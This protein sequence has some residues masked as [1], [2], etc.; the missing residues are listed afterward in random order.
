M[1]A[2]VI[3]ANGQ[4]GTKLAAYSA[5]H[6]STICLTRRELDVT[7]RAE[8]QRVL[9]ELK[10]D[11][12]FN[13]SAY[14]AVDKAESETNAAKAV[15]EE[16]PRYIAETM[17]E[18]NGLLVHYSTDYV[19]NGQG[20]Q[21]WKETDTP[22]PQNVYGMTKWLG[23]CAIR[24]SG[25]RHLIFR[26]SWVY[27]D[28][29]NNFVKTMLRLA[30]ERETLRVVADQ[31]G[32]PCSA[33]LAAQISWNCAARALRNEPLSGTFHL[34]PSGETSWHHF[35]EEIISD[36]KRAGLPLKVQRIEAIPSSEYPVPAKRPLNS[37]LDC[38][39]LEAVLGEPLPSWQGELERVFPA[40]VKL[41]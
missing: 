28:I 16:A 6:A 21:P 30:L 37:R 4:V 18:W 13:A 40:I 31:F 19:F 12:V 14:T 35:A 24:E 17:R 27:S 23:E 5:Q 2:L 11:V 32:S 1:R 25:V 36:G 29:G 22:D 20:V 38:S 33:D 26:I 41:F 10:P 3:G 8:V 15:N 7:Q 9:K 39:K 34:S